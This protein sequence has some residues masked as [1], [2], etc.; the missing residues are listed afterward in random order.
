MPISDWADVMPDIIIYEKMLTRDIYG[1]PVTYDYPTTYRA[2]VAG[3]MRRVPSRIPGGQD[4]IATTSVWVL[5]VIDGLKLDDRITLPDG[6]MPPILSFD[7]VS[8]ETG[9]HHTKILFGPV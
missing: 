6:T 4:V 8:D 7:H 5:G 3:T 2:R 1:K 9:D